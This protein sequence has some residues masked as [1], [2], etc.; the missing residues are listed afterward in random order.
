MNILWYANYDMNLF[1]GIIIFGAK[2]LYLLIIALFILSFIKSPEKRKQIIWLSVLALPIIFIISRIASWIYFDPRPFVVGK[3]TPLIPHVSDNGFPS[4]HTLLAAGIASIAWFFNKKFS[5]FLFI[6]GILVGVSRV[7]AGVHHLT[8]IIGAIIIAVVGTAIAH[9]Y[10]LP[11]IFHRK[12]E[13]Q[14]T[15]YL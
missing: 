11:K 1:N 15:P 12:K 8:D 3:F 9:Y 14:N 13:T 5:I 7:Y 4:D 6:L 10:I 2:Y